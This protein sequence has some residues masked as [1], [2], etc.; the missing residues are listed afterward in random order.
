MNILLIGPD[1]AAKGGIATVIH[2]FQKAKAPEDVRF[3]VHKTW[4]E[5]GKYWT[6]LKAF[7]TF[8]R[9][10]K[11]E[12]CQILHFHVA[13][14]GSFYR[15]SLLL[16]L[17]PKH[18]KTIFHMH[19][20]QF[21]QFYQ[22]SPSWAKGWIRFTLSR[23]NQLVVLS[24]SWAAFYQT[25]TDTPIEVLPNAVAVPEESLYDP[26]AKWI[27]TL[28]R[29]GQRKGSFD[30]LA[31]AKAMAISFPEVRFMLFG[32][33]ENQQVAQQLQEEALT[34]V[35]LNEWVATDA[36]PAVFRKAAIHFLPSYHEGLPMAILETMAAGIPNVTTKVGGIPELIQSG[37]N[38]Y[39]V[40]AG[41]IQAMIET[42]S[43]LLANKEERIKSGQQARAT[44]EQQYALTSYMKRWQKIYKKQL[45]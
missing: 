39:I 10:I 11:K 20:S 24:S 5:K 31:V 36:L 19:A 15:K 1:P 35:F 29:I 34:N 12:R 27:I 13:Q 37:E 33:Q 2:N 18:C 21:D 17:A 32:D 28:G 26:T 9:H 4:S 45:D 3:V 14:K 6:Q 40:A 23:V 44:I 16:L 30:L 43:Q 42:L 25:I 8:R 22:N 41:D 38:G 7:L